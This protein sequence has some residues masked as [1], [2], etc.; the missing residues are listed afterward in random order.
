MTKEKIS[1]AFKSD[2]PQFVERAKALDVYIQLSPGRR[3][4][5]PRAY[6]LDG[7]QQLTGYLTK[8]GGLPFTHEDAVANIDKAL[9][10]VETDRAEM[11][12]MTI[13]ER[14]ERVLAEIQKIDP[15]YR[16]IG[17]AHFPGGD[18]GHCFF[19]ADYAGDVDL[20]GVGVVARARAKW[21]KGDS[22]T[23]QMARYCNA[24]AYSFAEYEG[25]A[26]D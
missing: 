6:W 19:N 16:Q 26:D 24:L 21:C 22:A 11:I 9:T 14:F 3:N 8:K 23:Q 1:R 17:V 7:R 13:R 12:G 2:F 18:Q 15:V 10:A 20:H 5:R 25:Q 4:G